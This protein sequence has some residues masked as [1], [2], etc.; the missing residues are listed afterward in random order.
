MEK[1]EEQCDKSELEA[2]KN[3][4]RTYLSLLI[5]LQDWQHVAL[6][7]SNFLQRKSITLY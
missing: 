7:H 6:S 3:N 5:S 4:F 2:W 1:G